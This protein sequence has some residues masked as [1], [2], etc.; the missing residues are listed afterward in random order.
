[1]DKLFKTRDEAVAAA[2]E[3]AR[4]KHDRLPMPYEDAT[5]AV[6]GVRVAGASRSVE[7]RFLW[8]R[9]SHPFEAVLKTVSLQDAIDV[10]LTAEEGKFGWAESEEH[11]LLQPCRYD[12]ARGLS[13]VSSAL[14]SGGT[15][16]EEQRQVFKEKQWNMAYNRRALGGYGAVR[17]QIFAQLKLALDPLLIER[18][19][20]LNTDYARYHLYPVPQPG[21][22]WRG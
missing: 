7:E 9:F 22:V 21:D 10:M 6:W 18:G 12:L 17:D 2:L 15:I 16:R 11:R 3:W 8:P 19:F 13:L 1:M 20:Y 5:H 4:A 14:L